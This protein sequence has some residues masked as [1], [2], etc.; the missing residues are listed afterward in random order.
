MLKLS[1]VQR[2]WCY[3]STAYLFNSGWNSPQAHVAWIEKYFIAHSRLLHNF[4]VVKLQNFIAVKQKFCD[5][6]E[7]NH[8]TASILCVLRPFDE[9]RV[10]QHKCSGGHG[11][12]WSSR[13]HC[14]W[15]CCCRTSSCNGAK[16]VDPIYLHHPDLSSNTVTDVFPPCF[17]D[18]ICSLLEMLC[19]VAHFR[20]YICLCRMTE[21]KNHISRLWDSYEWTHSQV[22][23]LIAARADVNEAGTARAS[24]G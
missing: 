14:G 24:N 20:N 4:F 17:F 1:W 6:I 23:R 11:T 19:F 3:S 15:G 16:G 5:A 10:W 21:G 18:T 9:R 13:C 22:G 2:P 7:S 8:P 12:S